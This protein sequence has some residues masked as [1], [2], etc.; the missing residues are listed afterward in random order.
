M[1]ESAD[2]LK[3]VLNKIQFHLKA[4]M[5]TVAALEERAKKDG[6]KGIEWLDMRGIEEKKLK[7]IFDDLQQ[8]I[9]ALPPTLRG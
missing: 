3:A 7:A 2:T 6:M 8:L 1:A 5:I 4:T 9:D